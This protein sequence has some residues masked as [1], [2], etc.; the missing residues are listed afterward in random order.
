[1]KMKRVFSVLLSALIV[2]ASVTALPLS[3]GAAS[4]EQGVVDSVG[5]PTFYDGFQIDI[6]NDDEAILYKYTYDNTNVTIPERIY[7]RKIIEIADY[8]FKDNKTVERIT[9]PDTVKKIG[10]DII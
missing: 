3:A 2:S 8:A 5:F 1:M 9:I 6:I 10:S 4:V 7:D